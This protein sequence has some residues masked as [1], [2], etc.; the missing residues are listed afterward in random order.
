ME[1]AER[2][3]PVT[4]EI[5]EGIGS[6]VLGRAGPAA[7]TAAR[8]NPAGRGGQDLLQ[9]Q[10]EPPAVGEV[11]V[12]DEPLGRPQTQLGDVYPRCGSS[13]KPTPPA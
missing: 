12:I 11:V 2:S 3:V 10:V 9:T 4:M 7:T 6:P 8:G 13:R 5:P 1:L